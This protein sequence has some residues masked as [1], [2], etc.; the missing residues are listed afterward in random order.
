MQEK[1]LTGRKIGLPMLLLAILLHLASIAGF[2]LSIV[3]VKIPLVVLCVIVMFAVVFIYPG[4]KVLKPQEAL[5]LTL[6]GNYKGTLKGEAF[7]S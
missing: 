3:F 1:V 4:L 7:I 2:V 5:V 6:F